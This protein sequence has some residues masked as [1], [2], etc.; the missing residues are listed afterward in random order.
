MLATNAVD[1]CAALTLFLAMRVLL[2][3]SRRV[4]CVF[5][6]IMQRYNLL[7]AGVCGPRMANFLGVVLPWLVCIPFYTGSGFSN[8]VN[9]G[10]IIFNSTVSHGQATGERKKAQQA[11]CRIHL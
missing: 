6:A 8:V 1:V 9:W 5:A 11:V 2:V 3:V 10:G 7:E 4:V